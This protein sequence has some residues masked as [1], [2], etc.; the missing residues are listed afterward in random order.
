MA[1]GYLSPSPLYYDSA[2]EQWIVVHRSSILVMD[3]SV[4]T[5]VCLNPGG[6]NKLA[7]LKEAIMELVP[8]F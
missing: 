3:S 5:W 2:S 6:P 4:V 8:K 1:P 7:I